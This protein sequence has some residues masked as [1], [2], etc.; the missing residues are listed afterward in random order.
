MTKIRKAVG[1]LVI[2]ENRLLLVRK[3]MMMDGNS[4]PEAIEP[5]WDFPKGG[6]KGDDI[7][8]SDAVLRELAE[9]IGTTKLEIVKQLPDFIFDFPEDVAE[10]IGYTGQNTKMYLISFTGD[11]STLAPQDEEIDAIRFFSKK[12]AQKQVQFP[13]SAEYIDMYFDIA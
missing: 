5:F 11:P 8:Y 13:A 10:K 9:E 3:V 4:G 6:V 2:Y 12:E 1:A 7:D